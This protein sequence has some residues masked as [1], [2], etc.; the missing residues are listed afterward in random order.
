MH[1]TLDPHQADLPAA[2]ALA[3][4]GSWIRVGPAQWSLLDSARRLLQDPNLARRERALLN[5]VVRISLGRSGHGGALMDA[6]STAA[7]SPI[8]AERPQG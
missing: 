2:G 6:D 4:P 3:E 7:E 5:G 1:S 8:R